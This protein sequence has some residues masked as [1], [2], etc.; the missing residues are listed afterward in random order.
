MRL[1]R[2]TV[3]LILV[4]LLAVASDSG[5][6]EEN[7]KLAASVDQLRHVIGLWSVTSEFLNEDGSVAQS[8]QGTYEFDWVVPD[9]VVMGKSDI[10]AI[11][12]SAGILFY[13]NEKKETI[14]MV[15]V[16]ADGYLWIM[17]GPLGDETRTTQE[18]KS[19]EGK[20]SQLRFTRFNVGR[21]SFESRMEYTEDGGKT[22]KPGNHQVFRRRT[23]DK[24][25][26]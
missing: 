7:A 17:T 3:P 5:A 4:P 15:S 23:S 8:M 11:G 18:F 2:F 26:M 10:P 13:V 22:W 6:G 16:G 19:Q 25:G 12:R 9:K 24:A 1:L 21:D 14:E 20:D